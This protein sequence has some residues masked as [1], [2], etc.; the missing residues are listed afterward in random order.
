MAASVGA[1]GWAGRS[2]SAAPET[3]TLTTVQPSTWATGTAYVVDPTNG[4]INKVTNGGNLYQCR[5]NH[6][7]SG[8]NEPTGTS[9]TATWKYLGAAPNANNTASGSLLLALSLGRHTGAGGPLATPTDNDSGSF[10]LIR[11]QTYASFTDWAIGA[12]RRSAATNVKT[13]Y[14]SSVT[15][16]GTSTGSGAGEEA[17]VG[18]LELRNVIVG[19]PHADVH[20]ERSGP[21]GGTVTG[22]SYTLTTRCLV[23]SVWGGNGNALS[24]GGLHSATP[25]SPLALVGNVCNL[26]SYT[27]N[28][29]FQ[30]AVAFAIRD[31]G[32]YADVWTTTEGA[33]LFTLAWPVSELEGAA[34]VTLAAAA[35]SAAGQ[36][37]IVGAAAPTLAD[38]TLSATGEGSAPITGE[39]AITLA[40]ATAS[41]AGAVS[42][43]GAGAITLADASVSAAGSV[44]IQ[45][46]A[47]M[48]LDA[49][50]VSAAGAV[51]VQ[52]TAVV[53]LDDA[54]ISAA[55]QVAVQGAC[56]VTLDDVALSAAGAS[57]IIGAAAVTLDDASGSGAGAVAVQGTS[58]VQLAPATLSGAGAVS[59][60]AGTITGELSATLEPASASAVGIVLPAPEPGFA[61]LVDAMDRAI[62]S[63]LG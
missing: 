1:T 7:S 2:Y 62:L 53:T 60:A 15:W 41:G 42:V 39:A 40:D 61:A 24:T 18:F 57:G 21:T 48:S 27:N 5:T 51:A 47:S 49:A 33:Q 50:T 32:T 19:A 25:Q 13:G 45:G 11:R 52:G 30:A 54:S 34:S 31:A 23:I 10:T 12:F 59:G 44:A 8:A 26:V 17:A 16:A 37:A 6:T 36:V 14:T 63:H 55:G 38:A 58:A 3:G 22:A 29:Y 56:A 28:G 35:L 46:A 43:Q 20:V 9:D 4:G